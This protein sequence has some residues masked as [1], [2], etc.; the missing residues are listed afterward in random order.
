MK[1][2]RQITNKDFVLSLISRDS[3]SL[4]QLLQEEKLSGEST[5]SITR[6][7]TDMILLQ[8]MLKSVLQ[9]TTTLQTMGFLSSTQDFWK[10]VKMLRVATHSTNSSVESGLDCTE[11]LKMNFL[12]IW[13]KRKKD[14]KNCMQS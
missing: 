8:M 4:E 6:L 10:R 9:Q 2:K 11:H 3:K 7:R 14:L 1:D 5:L 12:T 13:K